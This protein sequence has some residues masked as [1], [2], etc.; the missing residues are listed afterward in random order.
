MEVYNI[1]IIGKCHHKVRH[2]RTDI[3]DHDTADH[4]HGHLVHF[5][6]GQQ[7]EA[8]GE[9]GTYKCRRHHDPGANDH[10]SA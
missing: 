6:C 2:R 7:H 5:S 4:Q 9:H 8:H 3:A 1:G 10:T